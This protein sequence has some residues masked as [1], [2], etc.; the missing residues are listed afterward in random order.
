MNCK[1]CGNVIYPGDQICRY[2]GTKVDVN[3]TNNSFNTSGNTYNYNNI[4][5]GINQINPNYNNTQSSINPANQINPNYNNVSSNTNS[6]NQ[7]NPNYNNIQPN[8]NQMNQVNSSYN[9]NVNPNTNSINQFNSNYN[10][11]SVNSNVN[12]INTSYNNAQYN[13]N[14]MGSNYTSKPIDTNN[15]INEE[16][17]EKKPKKRKTLVLILFILVIILVAIMILTMPK[18]SNVSSNTNNT[19]NTDK[20]KTNDTKKT[21]ETTITYNGFEFNK[22]D[23]Y[24]YYESDGILYISS[25]T[26]DF[27]YSIKISQVNFDTL[28]TSYKDLQTKLVSNGVEAVDP[29]IRNSLNREFIT[30][31]VIEEADSMIYFITKANDNLIF[32]GMVTNNTKTLNEYKDLEKVTNTINSAKYTDTGS[33]YSTTYGDNLNIYRDNG[34]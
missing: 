31:A 11:N 27:K 10:T 29:Q 13:N 23:G 5:N 28:K 4:Q 32:E 12:S 19:S 33:K 7:V 17:E 16:P 26:G 20:K 24:N 14:S 9:N 6:I 3:P 18:K 15:S 34:N 30:C 2:C 8:I 22:L 21:K 1:R 25:T